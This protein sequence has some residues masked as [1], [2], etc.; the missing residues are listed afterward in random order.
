MVFEITQTGE[1]VSIFIFTLTPFHAKI[2]MGGTSDCV[3]LKD[4]ICDVLLLLSS[5]SS[6]FCAFTAI[7]LLPLPFG[8]HIF[9]G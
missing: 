4:Q 3:V 2:L 9:A 7:A 8:G 6:M 1:P 5:G